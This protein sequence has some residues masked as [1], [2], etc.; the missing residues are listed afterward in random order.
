MFMAKL[1][2]ATE[3]EPK[4]ISENVIRQVF[5]PSQ[6]KSSKLDVVQDVKLDGRTGTA[7]NHGRK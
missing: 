2:Q 4:K 7:E 3:V 1:P 5:I 6:Q